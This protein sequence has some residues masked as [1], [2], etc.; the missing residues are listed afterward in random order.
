MGFWTVSQGYNGT[1]THQAEWGQ[2]LDF[3]I[4]DDEHNTYQYPGTL[5]EHF[6]CYN[7]PVLACADGIV[8]QIVNHVD[9]NP[10]GSVNLTENWGNTAVLR[11]A[12]GLYSKV[13]HL[14]K[15]S[16]KINPGDAV[17]QGDML[18]LCGNSGRSPEPHLHFQIQATPYIG[19]KTLAYPFAYYF[20]RNP[21][22][23]S[24]ESYKIPTEGKVVSNPQINQSIKKAFDLQ[25]GYTAK[26]V[27]EQGITEN[28]EVFKDVLGQSYLC[29]KNTGAVAYFINNGT[30]FYF[31]S[32]YG[33]NHSLLYY[34]YLAA[35]KIVFSDAEGVVADD[36]LPLQV[37]ENKPLLWLQD[38]L[39][40]F[41]RFINI[42]YQSSALIQK[43]GL[44]IGAKQYLEITGKKSQ[45]MEAVVNIDQ[46]N[47]QA[48]SINIKGHHIKVQWDTKNI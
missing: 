11:H 35:Y 14:K 12:V 31:T 23:N 39:A 22:I 3:V 42:S 18:G 20:N 45:T 19:S 44:S 16:I 28:W 4:S 1:L 26:L 38:F 29:S 17:K 6:Y 8:E 9:D 27:S 32:Y 7:K 48:F 21:Q 33:S 25:P 41:Y 36:Q 43:K 24:L 37:M 15:N 40:P 13:S 10:I 2:A 47:L 46:G 30:M 34:F 5:P